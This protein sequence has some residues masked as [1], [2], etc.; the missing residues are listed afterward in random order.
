MQSHV[1]LAVFYVV[2]LVPLGWVR[3]FFA[4]PLRCRSHEP[5]WLARAPRPR[6]VEDA[7]RQF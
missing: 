3:S 4:D 1:I 7:R 6:T 5:S 2:L